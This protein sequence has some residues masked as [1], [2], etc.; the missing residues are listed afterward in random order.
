MFL[1]KTNMGENNMSKKTISS[2]SR[3][4]FF[5]QLQQHGCSGLLAACKPADNTSGAGSQQKRV[6]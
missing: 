3:R 1:I 6:S 5:K 4:K 2:N